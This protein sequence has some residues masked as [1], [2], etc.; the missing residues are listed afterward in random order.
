[1]K[2][3]STGDLFMGDFCPIEDNGDE[4]LGV[5]SSENGGTP[6]SLDG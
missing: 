3:M 5:S 6:S 4:Y 2:R 1:M